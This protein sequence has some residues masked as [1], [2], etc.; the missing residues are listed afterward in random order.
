MQLTEIPNFVHI[1]RLTDKN[2]LISVT[3]ID[4]CDGR[5]GL[6]KVGIKS[7]KDNK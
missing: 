1:V 2:S 3:N 7:K 4:D 5:V 6:Q